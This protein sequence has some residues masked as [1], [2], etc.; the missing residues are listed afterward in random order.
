[1][2]RK[3]LSAAERTVATTIKYPESVDDRIAELAQTWGV[4]PPEVLRRVIYMG[5]GLAEM[6]NNNPAIVDNLTQ[7]TPPPDKIKPDGKVVG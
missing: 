5:L 4:K 1:M 6:L 2:G 3:K 7:R